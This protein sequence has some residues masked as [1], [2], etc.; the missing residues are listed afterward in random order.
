MESLAQSFVY[1][2]LCLSRNSSISFWLAHKRTHT[3]ARPL[4]CLL[5]FAL[6]LAHQYRHFCTHSHIVVAWQRL[7]KNKND[8]DDNDDNETNKG[9]E[10][11]EEENSETVLKKY[12]WNE[13]NKDG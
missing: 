10:E 5:S 6:T 4:A 11:E 3:H 9:S 2:H 12:N 1:H 8:D 7:P 13:S